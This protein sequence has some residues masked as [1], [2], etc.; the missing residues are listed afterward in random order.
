ML[1]IYKIIYLYIYEK[2][3]SHPKKYLM[4]I[5]DHPDYLN[6]FIESFE[7]NMCG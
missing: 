1:Y 5:E 3:I 2:M 6:Y 7:K 4:W